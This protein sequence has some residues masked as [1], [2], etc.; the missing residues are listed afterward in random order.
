MRALMRALVRPLLIGVGW[1]ALL[2]LPGLLFAGWQGWRWWSAPVGEWFVTADGGAAPGACAAAAWTR[3]VGGGWAVI[4]PGGLIDSADARSRA[5]GILRAAFDLNESPSISRPTLILTASAPVWVMTAPIPLDP[6]SMTL[7]SEAP[8][9]QPAA[10]VVLDARTGERRDL[11]A[12]A[13]SAAPESCRREAWA[14]VDALRA[15]ARDRTALVTGVGAW[16]AWGALIVV[17]FLR[18]RR[19]KRSTM[20][21]VFP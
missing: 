2:M 16:G 1:L 5:D 17:M 13:Q 21:S 12:V 9:A 10:V 6:T 4:A 3:I 11:I 7:M 20:E 18:Q 15:W 14:L 19:T 8:P